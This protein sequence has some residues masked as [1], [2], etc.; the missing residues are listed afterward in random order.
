MSPAKTRA[1]VSCETGNSVSPE[2][3][4]LAWAAARAPS[5]TPTWRP[6][7]R[8]TP[9][10]STASSTTFVHNSAGWWLIAPTINQHRAP[11]VNTAKP[12]PV[13]REPRFEAVIS[14]ARIVVAVAAQERM[15]A[16]RRQCAGRAEGS[17]LHLAAKLHDAVGG[18]LEKL[19]RAFRIA[20]HPGEQFLAPDR[21]PRPRRGEQSLPGEEEAGVHHLALRTAILELRQGRRNVDLLHE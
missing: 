6:S 20:Q 3:A 16:I 10:A 7:Q 19:H 1:R 2:F 11:I 21:H 18:K 8:H 14:A 17:D 12:Y 15:S 4:S 13:T 5:S 9:N